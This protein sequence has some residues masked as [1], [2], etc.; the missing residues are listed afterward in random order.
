MLVKVLLNNQIKK[1]DAGQ[2]DDLDRTAAAPYTSQLMQDGSASS[3]EGLQRPRWPNSAATFFFSAQALNAQQKMQKR[4]L[5]VS[6]IFSQ[7]PKQKKKKAQ[8]P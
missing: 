1:Q 5:I 6:L 3:E 2:W 4:H 7:A 8:E